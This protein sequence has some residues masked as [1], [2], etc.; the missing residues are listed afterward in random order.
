MK[1]Q[2]KFYVIFDHNKCP[3]SETEDEKCIFRKSYF[4]RI[5]P[6]HVLEIFNELFFCLILKILTECR[7]NDK[8]EQRQTIPKE[9]GQCGQTLEDRELNSN[10]L[11]WSVL[12]I[13]CSYAM[14]NAA[15]TEL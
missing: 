15:C 13:A 8:P 6:R 9:T 1:F 10:Y 12:C 4:H 2:D 3:P 11:Y 5:Q 14:Q 7:L